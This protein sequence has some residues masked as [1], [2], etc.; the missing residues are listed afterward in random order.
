MPNALIPPLD[1]ADHV[2]GPPDAALEL[3]MFGD[4]QCPY[5]L[6]S[7]AVLKRVF[8]RVGQPLRFAFR[9]LPVIERHPLAQVAAEVS[10][11]A[12]AQGSFWEFHD[13]VY[14]AQSRLTEPTV[15]IAVA[16]EIGLD[17]DR[18]LR[19]LEDGRWR[20]RVERD[21]RSA[22]RSGALG[23]PTFFVNGLRHDDVYDA[24]SLVA[25]LEG[26]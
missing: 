15:L 7:Q 2:K 22:E 21:M 9:H 20:P 26:G 23:T 11:A 19:E 24:G 6:A 17:A 12:A 8:E 4:F 10:E 1:E 3:V 25:A 5:C 14:A 16:R 18:V 13:A